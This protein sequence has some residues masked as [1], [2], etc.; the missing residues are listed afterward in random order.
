MSCEVC[1]RPHHQPGTS[2]IRSITLTH[3]C[4]TLPYIY[5]ISETLYSQVNSLRRARNY[6]AS[7]ALAMRYRQQLQRQFNSL[8]R[9]LEGFLSAVSQGRVAGIPLQRVPQYTVTPGLQGSL[10]MY[11]GL[12]GSLLVYTRRLSVHGATRRLSVHGPRGVS[13]YTGPRGVSQYTGPRGV[14][15]HTGPRGVSQHTGPPGSLLM[16]LPPLSTR[17]HQAPC[18]CTRHPLC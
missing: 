12:R 8:P 1:C 11:T 13:Q 14:S 7:V 16:Y 9:P 4:S 10:L 17:S 3:T 5:I 15:Q 6:K 18:W 2:L